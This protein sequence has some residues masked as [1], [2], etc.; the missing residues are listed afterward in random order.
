[1][2]VTP[3]SPRMRRFIMLVDRFVLFVTRRWLMLANVFI[4]LFAGLPFLAP[5]LM[6][7]G[8]TLPAELIYKAYSLSCHQLAYRTFFFFGA[9]PTYTV[10]ELQRAL[11]VPNPANDVFY[12]RD[13]IGNAQVGYKMAWCERDAAIY[14]AL[15]AAGVLFAFLRAR[16]KPLNW[17][18]YLFLIA[19]MALD[20]L[21]QLF[22]L[23]ES[24]AILR[25]I[26]GALFGAGSVWL[27]YP[28]VEEAMR[29]AYAQAKYQYERGRAR[30]L[31]EKGAIQ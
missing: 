10:D 5:L 28:Y 22:G 31:E 2:T 26:T 16:L 30:E 27:V 4:F 29:D 1:M 24:D 12:W 18:I 11:G 23:R 9:Q 20:G 15:F 8:A 19:P 6:H 25:A 7:W 13:F 17:R 3:V 14:I 21:T